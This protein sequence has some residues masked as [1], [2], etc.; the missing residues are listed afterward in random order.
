MTSP[1]LANIDPFGFAQPPVYQDI[2][3]AQAE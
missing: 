1:G 3:W 2:G